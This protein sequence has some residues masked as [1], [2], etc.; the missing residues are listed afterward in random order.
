MLKN[1]TLLNISHS[2]C[3]TVYVNKHVSLTEALRVPT[4]GYNYGGTWVLVSSYV[5]LCGCWL[6]TWKTKIIS[7]FGYS[8]FVEGHSVGIYKF[9]NG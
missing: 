5:S 3:P 8:T 6:D 4:K 1:K 2:T 7:W 9:S